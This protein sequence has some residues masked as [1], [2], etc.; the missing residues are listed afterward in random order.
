MGVGS[1]QFDVGDN[2]RHQARS[3]ITVHNEGCVGRAIRESAKRVETT[4]I[5]TA[6]KRERE[7][8]GV[9]CAGRGGRLMRRCQIGGGVPDGMVGAG[10]EG[11]AC[12]WPVPVS[13]SLIQRSLVQ[14]SARSLLAFSSLRPPPLPPASAASSALWLA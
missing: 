10:Q 11:R 9:V 12:R 4:A 7:G 1:V 8:G 5:W 14:A 3:S 13:V 6:G 2:D